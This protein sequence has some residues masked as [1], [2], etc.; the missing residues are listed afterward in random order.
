MGILVVM[1]V[2]L[3]VAVTAGLGANYY[4][5]V[6]NEKDPKE[7]S[8]VTAVLGGLTILGA[9]IIALVLSQT[10]GSYG[11]A[12]TAAKQEADI[13]DTLF[14]SAEYVDQPFR[15]SLQA[16]AACY[17]RAVVGSEW[18]ELAHGD[19]ST[20]P[21]NWTG[22]GER[23]IRRALLQMGTTAKGFSLVQSADARR[24]ELRNERVTQANPT[25]PESVFW[26]MVLLLAL[27]LGSIAF[28]IPRAQNASHLV[29]LLAV[30]LIFASIVFVIRNLD[31][32]FASVLAIPPTAMQT[33]EQDISEDYVSTYNEELPCNDRGEPRPA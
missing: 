6:V 11:K 17:A 25:V 21:N 3:V 9:F 15:K 5:G 16:A 27:S 4:S 12:Q 7:G 33:T 13:V 10:A 24:G 32:P 29:A 8:S 22:T 18:D 14:E 1:I 23:G 26:L 31:R 30:T 2:V 20:V 28:G 19:R